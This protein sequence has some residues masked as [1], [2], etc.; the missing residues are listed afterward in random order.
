MSKTLALAATVAALLPVSQVQANQGVTLDQF[1]RLVIGG[2]DISQVIAPVAD[3]SLMARPGTGGA[4][5][6]CEPPKMARP[7]TGGANFGCEPPK[8]ARPGTGGAN[9]GCEPPAA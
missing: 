3:D 7:G 9:F 2:Q 8:M 5:F 1:G 4:N 6:G